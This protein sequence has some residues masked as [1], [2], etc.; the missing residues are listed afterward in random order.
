MTFQEKFAIEELK[1]IECKSWTWS[2][3]PEQ[4]TIASTIIS[5]NQN[6]ETFA[7]LSTEEIKD[8][9]IFIKKID[10]SLR[11]LLNPDKINY[12][13]LMMID[14][15]LHTHIIPRYKNKKLFNKNYFDDSEWP[16]PPNLSGKHIIL[17]TKQ[18]NDLI[19]QL[20]KL[21]YLIN[22]EFSK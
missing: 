7:S 6:K 1:I 5:H 10:K 19:S 13:T 21:Y 18:K 11:E 16:K 20:K 4:P 17:D 22:T 14:D 8:Y 12:L 15:N 2:L 9:A 3:R